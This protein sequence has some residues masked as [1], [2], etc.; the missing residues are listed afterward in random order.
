V[1]ADE[2]DAALAAIEARGQRYVMAP[3]LDDAVAGALDAT[4]PG[5][6]ILLLGA[7]GMDRGRELISSRGTA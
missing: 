3:R 4:R 7:Q 2:R 1:Q 6:L 5:D